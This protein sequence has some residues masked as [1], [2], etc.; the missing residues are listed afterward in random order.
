MNR[1]W[2]KSTYSDGSGGECVEARTPDNGRTVD[3]RDTQNRA[4]GHVTVSATAWA[5]LLAEVKADDL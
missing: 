5:A 2:R 4:L 3:V 1:E